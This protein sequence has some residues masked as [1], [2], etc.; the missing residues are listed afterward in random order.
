M[1]HV[2]RT[3]VLNYVKFTKFIRGIH[4]VSWIVHSQM[5]IAHQPVFST[6]LLFM[7]LAQ[8]IHSKMKNKN[9]WLYDGFDLCC[10]N[11][12]LQKIDLSSNQV[13]TNVC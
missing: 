10:I 2:S 13:M 5:L 12:E 3:K 11:Q 9:Q 4:S 6:S 8:Q 1:V 7:E